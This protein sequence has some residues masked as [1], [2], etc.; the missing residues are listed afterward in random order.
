MDR[1]DPE[2]SFAAWLKS[3]ALNKCRDHAR[4]TFVR[5]AVFGA[6]PADGAASVREESPSPE[7]ALIAR[8]ELSAL[9]RAIAALPRHLR[10][11]LML[12]AVDGMSQAAAADALNCTIKA[13]E[14]R[15]SRARKIIAQEIG[16]SE[17]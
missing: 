14:Y 3:I 13:V 6:S 7:Q 12:T 2:R 15:V 4:R 8:D 17:K 1:F 5:K 9:A 10:D 16:I 11:A